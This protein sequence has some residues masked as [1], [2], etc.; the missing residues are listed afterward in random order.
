MR[1]IIIVISL[2]VAAALM[3]ALCILLMPLLEHT[4]AFPLIQRVLTPIPYMIGVAVGLLFIWVGFFGDPTTLRKFTG[5]ASLLPPS[6]GIPLARAGFVVGG[7]TI[8]AIVGINI[9][10]HSLT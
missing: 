2:G 1:S 5:L 10:I 4:S 8:L 9:V 3:V 7:L 6:I